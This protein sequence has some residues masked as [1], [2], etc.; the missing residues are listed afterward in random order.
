MLR[1]FLKH[2][3]DNLRPH[4][5]RRLRVEAKDLNGQ[6]FFVIEEVPWFPLASK[7]KNVVVF[8]SMPS[9]GPEG[10]AHHK[11]FYKH[12]SVERCIR[13]A[14]DAYEKACA[15][16]GVLIDVTIERFEHT[17]VSRSRQV[18]ALDT[19]IDWMARNL[20]VIGVPLLA[21][22]LVASG[23]AIME[24]VQLGPVANVVSTAPDQLFLSLFL[25]FWT[26]VFWGLL[27]VASATIL[28]AVTA[29][30]ILAANPE[31]KD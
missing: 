22:V 20:P 5:N 28:G 31:K 18:E 14:V 8:L 25:Q 12:P 7:R 1:E 2:L 21:L 27:M 29:V 4:Y 10:R 30:A 19:T 13:E 6:R 16:R 17:V 26:Y 3:A 24:G 11:L 23:V 9:P 15:Q